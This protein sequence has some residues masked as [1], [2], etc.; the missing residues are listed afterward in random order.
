MGLSL[1]KLR[2]L[3]LCAVLGTLGACADPGEGVHVADREFPEF[4]RIYPILLRDC[5]FSTCHGSEDRFFKVWGPGR[6]RLDSET[7]A[8]DPTTGNEASASFT[9]ALSMLDDEH[10]ERSLLLRKPL[11][12]EAGGAPHGGVDRFGR[13]I[14]RTAN[15]AGYLAIAR[16]VFEAMEEPE[17]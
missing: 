3:G 9:I 4:Q 11:A 17:E 14:Y 5:G 2:R 1:R 10:P 6:A 16:W 12:V 8:F 7:A 13:D 15:D